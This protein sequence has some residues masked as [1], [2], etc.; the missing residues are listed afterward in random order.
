[1]SI[2]NTLQ[3][4]VPMAGRGS[5]FQEA[6]YKDPKP[7]IQVGRRRMIE[8]VVD[9]IRPPI[10]HRFIFVCQASHLLEYPSIEDVLMLSGKDTTIV[11]L[12]EVTQGAACTVLAARQYLVDSSPLMI[13][14]SDQFIEV[15][16]K[17]YLAKLEDRKADGLIMTFK[18]NDPKWS[19]CSQNRNAEVTKVVEKKVI[20]DE[21]TV[22]IYNFRRAGDFIKGAEDMIKMDLRVN[23]EFYV[24]PVY[25][26]MIANGLRIVTHAI[27]GVGEGMHGLGTPSD[28]DAFL[29]S[30]S[31]ARNNA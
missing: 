14:N 28:L 27:K 16:M 26:Q 31:F 15:S 20:S 24:A 25:N 5:R 19:Y 2:N 13:A 29:N 22:G 4:V 17:D 9:S 6:G 3:I 7:L 23:G 10:E 18:S 21:A 30:E 8:W 1:M 12:N 11:R